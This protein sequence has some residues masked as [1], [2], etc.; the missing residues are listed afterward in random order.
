MQKIGNFK[1]GTLEGPGKIIFKDKD[2]QYEGNF[3]KSILCGLGKLIQP[4]V[5]IF[6]CSF[7]ND[8]IE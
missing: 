2:I 1:N 4:N 6:K 5:A 8:N 7:I 3:Q